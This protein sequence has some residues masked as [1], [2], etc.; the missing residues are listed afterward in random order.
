MNEKDHNVEEGFKVTQE[1][2][3]AMS[4]REKAE[5]YQAY[6]NKLEAEGKMKLGEKFK[7]LSEKYVNVLLDDEYFDLLN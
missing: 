3:N 4:D 6:F 1:Q 5:H 7:E 2:W